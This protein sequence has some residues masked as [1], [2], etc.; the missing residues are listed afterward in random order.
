MLWN[1]KYDCDCFFSWQG[2]KNILT[3]KYAESPPSEV[4]IC[5]L[6]ME[7]NMSFL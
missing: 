7:E 3:S 1:I 5:V 6:E 4:S 2:C